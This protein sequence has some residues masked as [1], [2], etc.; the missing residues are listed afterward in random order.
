KRR[1]EALGRIAG[2][3]AASVLFEAPSR[4]VDTLCDL[5]EACGEA[6][7]AAL[8]RELT[9]LHEEVARGTLGELCERFTEAP[10]GE[11]TLVVGGASEAEQADEPPDEDALSARIEAGLASGQGAKELAQELAEALGLPRREVYQR[12][13]A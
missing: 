13:L 10:R 5:R 2:D 12:I 3:A 11:I 6:R 8:C 4:V 1:R 9:K 7:P